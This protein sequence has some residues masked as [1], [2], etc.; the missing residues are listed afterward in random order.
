MIYHRAI[1][2]V[3][4]GPHPIKREA[5][6]VRFRAGAA[7]AA[8]L[9]VKAGE[10]VVVDWALLLPHAVTAIATASSTN[11]GRLLSVSPPFDYG[12]A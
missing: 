3:F 7:D 11:L 5:V 2:L 1:E 8:A 9:G 12:A 10:L 6:A 4:S